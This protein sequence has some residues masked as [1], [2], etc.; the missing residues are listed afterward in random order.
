M[1][2]EKKFVTEINCVTGETIQREFTEEEYAQAEI[3]AKTFA[4]QEAKLEAEQKAA[5]ELKA[6]AFAKLTALG[7]SEEEAKAIAG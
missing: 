3:D 2:R 4:E 5:A 7:L 6:S 1:A